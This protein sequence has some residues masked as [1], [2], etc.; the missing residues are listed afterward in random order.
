MSTIH[1]PAA[2]AVSPTEIVIQIY[3]DL[4]LRSALALATSCRRFYNIYALNEARLLERLAMNDQSLR[5]FE[6]C[7]FAK[8][9]ISV[10]E[11]RLKKN[12]T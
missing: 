9:A 7:N 1:L 6:D 4:D 8:Q 10:A 2:L 11:A 3:E 5:G 12:G